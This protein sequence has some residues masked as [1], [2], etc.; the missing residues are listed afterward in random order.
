MLE[1][2]QREPA[3]D[4]PYNNIGAVVV[5]RGDMSSTK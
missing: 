5:K 3:K 1:R 4:G 2:W